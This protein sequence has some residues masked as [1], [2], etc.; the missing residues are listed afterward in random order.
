[1]FLYLKQVFSQEGLKIGFFLK[2]Q[3]L[4]FKTGGD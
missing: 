2:V 4:L 1:M 3:K